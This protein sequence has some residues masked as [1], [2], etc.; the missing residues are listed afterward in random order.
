MRPPRALTG[1][2]L[3]ALGLAGLG[4]AGLL[5]SCSS[6]PAR[7]PATPAT[8]PPTPAPAS[9]TGPAALPSTPVEDPFP[10]PHQ[11][12]TVPAAHSGPLDEN[13]LPP[14]RALGRGWRP[15][16][17]PGDAEKGF[18]GNGSW[19]R[20][21]EGTEVLAGITPVGCAGNDPTATALPHPRHALEGTY[22]HDSGDTAAALALDF[23]TPAAA[24]DFLRGYAA[25]VQACGTP[26]GAGD[27]E[28]YRLGIIVLDAEDDLLIDRR[29]ESG[30]HT[31][32]GSWTEIATCVGTRVTLLTVPG[33]VDPAPLLGAARQAASP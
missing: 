4:L 25:S 15:Y 17:D 3:P 32:T 7:P 21:R 10:R 11:E 30:P 1:P 23:T 9:A 2:G 33:E 8:A 19:V 14:P 27:A 24:R 31:A 12:Q 28:A 29:Y 16:A 22:Q 13:A 18:R 5:T 20:E 26:T 6:T